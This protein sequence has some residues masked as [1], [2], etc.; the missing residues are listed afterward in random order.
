MYLISMVPIRLH[1][2]QEEDNLSTKD[3]MPEYILSPQ[4]PLFGG[5]TVCYADR[6]SQ[7]CIIMEIY[8]FLCSHIWRDLL[9]ALSCLLYHK[10]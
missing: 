8:Y 7:T 5:S 6:G 1:K 10:Q 9:G 4:C 3:E 2:P